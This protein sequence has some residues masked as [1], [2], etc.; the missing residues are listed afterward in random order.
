VK[1]RNRHLIQLLA[2]SV[3]RVCR[4]LFATCRNTT[5]ECEARISPYSRATEERFLYCNWHDGILVSLFSGRPLTMAALTSLHADGEYVAQMMQAVGV[6]PVRGSNKHGGTAAARQLMTFAADKHVT[7]TTDGPRG[8]RRVVKPGVV[9]LASQTGRRIVPVGCAA[10][11][12]WKPK[13]RWTD[14][15]VPCPFSKVF[16]VGGEPLAVPSGLSREQLAPYCA[17][18]Q[19]RMEQAQAQADA[20]ASDQDSPA[21]A[22]PQRQAA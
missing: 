20:L 13:G 8:P 2:C 21:A 9:F 11:R 6:V 7:I 17:E 4:C 16:I 1:L 5:I 19:R 10:T 14:L 15:L 3:A 12:A 22:A 18:L